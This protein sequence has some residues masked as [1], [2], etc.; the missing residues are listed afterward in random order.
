[1]RGGGFAT[2]FADRMSLIG[3]RLRYAFIS[4]RYPVEPRVK[5][6][7]GTVRVRIDPAARLVARG[8]AASFRASGPRPFTLVADFVNANDL[9]A[10]SSA[11]Y[12]NDVRATLE[13]DK[14]SRNI[15][16]RR[17]PNHVSKTK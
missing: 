3:R 5:Y 12:R 11:A 6:Q 10:D 16:S 9:A 1:M 13:L 2:S 4:A 14:Q 7:A 17:S 15:T 8:A